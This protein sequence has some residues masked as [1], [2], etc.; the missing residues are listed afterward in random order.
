MNCFFRAKCKIIKRTCLPDSKDDGGTA[1]SS[2][3][4][5]GIVFREIIVFRHETMLPKSVREFRPHAKLEKGH[6]ATER[7]NRSTR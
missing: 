1:L 4:F 3:S 6:Y 7:G 5:T 2:I